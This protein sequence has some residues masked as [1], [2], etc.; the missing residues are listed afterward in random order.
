MD[1]LTVIARTYSVIATGTAM[2]LDVERP[3]IPKT[4]MTLLRKNCNNSNGHSFL[5]TDKIPTYQD[6]PLHLQEV[7]KT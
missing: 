5:L 7:W 1:G 2:S 4:M 6:L 3:K